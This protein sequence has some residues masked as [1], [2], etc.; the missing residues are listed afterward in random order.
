M[1]VASPATV[2]RCGMVYLSTDVLSGLSIIDSFFEVNFLKTLKTDVYQHLLHLS[3]AN[4][5]KCMK[6]IKK[7]CG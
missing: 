6:F 5:E 2:S 7:K 1:A 3:K 4:Y